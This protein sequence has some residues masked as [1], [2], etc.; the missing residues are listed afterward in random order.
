MK[1]AMYLARRVL[2]HVFTIA[3]LCALPL[4]AYAQTPTTVAVDI[5]KAKLKWAWTQ[6]TGGPVS[7]FRIKCGEQTG[8]YTTAKAVANTARELT[9]ASVISA[10][11]LYFCAVFAA[12]E[13]GESGP[14]N[15]VSFKA[16]NVPLSATG[17]VIESQ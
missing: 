2:L 17:M 7:E 15:E 10:P 3:A 6:G 9:V 13:F 16:G 1:Q 12:N 4:A 5:T 11:G 8:V 14:S